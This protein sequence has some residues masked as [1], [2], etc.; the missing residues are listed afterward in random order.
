VPLAD[1]PKRF[2]RPPTSPTNSR[3]SRFALTRYTD[4]NPKHFEE[5]HLI[6]LSAGGAPKDPRNLWPEPRISECGAEKK[7]QL[8]IV[9][10]KMVCSQEITLAEA[11]HRMTTNWI[12]AWKQHVP[13][14]QNIGLRA[15]LNESH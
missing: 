2:V 13:S 6:A 10:Y 3:S 12:D 5:D 9:L 14:H 8:E 7:D 15:G 1:I 4:T 11:Q